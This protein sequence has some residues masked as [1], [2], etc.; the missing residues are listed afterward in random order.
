MAI[1]T[2]REG[3]LSSLHRERGGC[4]ART[5]MKSRGTDMR[6]RDLGVAIGDY[7]PGPSNSLTDVSGLRVGH[8]TLLRGDD[9]R[10]GAT[11]I[12]PHEGNPMSE[13]VYAGIHVLNGNGE[14]TSRSV[15][16]EWGLLASPI[17]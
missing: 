11:A 17:V 14:M 5:D 6:L 2:R 4:P 13:R 1:A 3:G 8:T 7:L 12:W 16:D 10:T 9:I 15:V